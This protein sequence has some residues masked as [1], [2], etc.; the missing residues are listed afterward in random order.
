[1][2][3][4]A[5]RQGLFAIIILISFLIHTTL[6]VISTGQQLDELKTQTGNQML[7]QLVEEVKLPLLSDDKVS[8]SVLTGRYITE[9]NVSNLTIENAEHKVVLQTGQAQLLSGEVLRQ[10][11]M[12]E[13]SLIGEVALT[14]RDTSNGEI[15]ASQ[16]VFILGAFIVHL[17]IWLIYGYIARPTRSQLSA[18]S[19]DVQDYVMNQHRTQAQRGRRDELPTNYSDGRCEELIQ[20]TL[21]NPLARQAPSAHDTS[22]HQAQDPAIEGLNRQQALN[23]YVQSHQQEALGEQQDTLQRNRSATVATPTG[24]DLLTDAQAYSDLNLNDGDLSEDHPNHK[25]GRQ[26]G[27]PPR[28][29]PWQNTALP[30][31]VPKRKP[32]MA[33]RPMDVACVQI[34]FHDPYHLIGTLAPDQSLPYFAL[35]TQLLQRTLSEMLKQPLLHGVEIKSQTSFSD[36]GAT[37]EFNSTSPHSKIALAAAMLAEA[38][39]MLHELTCA[40]F[41]ELKWFSANICIGV[42][43]HDVADNLQQ[44]L[45]NRAKASDIYTLLPL[46]GTKQL[47][48][49]IQ[50]NSLDNPTNV[51]ERDAALLKGVSDTMMQRLVDVRNAVLLSAETSKEAPND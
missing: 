40:K 51:Y 48:G 41:R 4:L 43:D 28:E 21:T 27:Q 6:L 38:Y 25:D 16:W 24:S 34:M 37:V 18:L 32:L 36:N 50:L 29:S 17:L 44:I 22:R 30:N 23:Q 9:N 33:K 49:H 2:T 13:D 10:K 39:M 1:M 20:P 15:I 12:F 46:L 8:L 5:P 47:S 45:Q 31:D 42:S 19:R 3:Y 26:T 11:V 14:L 35:C 7:A